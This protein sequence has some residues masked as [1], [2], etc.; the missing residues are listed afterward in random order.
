MDLSDADV[1]PVMVEYIRRFETGLQHPCVLHTAFVHIALSVTSTTCD[2]VTVASPIVVFSTVPPISVFPTKALKFAMSRSLLASLGA[3]LPVMAGTPVG[4]A[5][6]A[7]AFIMRRAVM[8]RSALSTSRRDTLFAA[9]QTTVFLASVIKSLACL[10]Y[11][12]PITVC[13]SIAFGCFSGGQGR[14]T[15]PC[16][17]HGLPGVELWVL[18]SR[19]KAQRVDI[20][21]G[22]AVRCA[23]E[24]RH[25]RCVDAIVWHTDTSRASQQRR[26]QGDPSCRSRILAGAAGRRQ[27]RVRDAPAP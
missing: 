26:F 18:D 14:P 17:R 4:R 3:Q 19:R 21:Q 23:D 9:E 24:I 27:I 8:R 7:A 12:V 1:L 10:G 15:A 25:S 5:F 16:G 13:V 22:V 6:A 11:D 20:R 2:G